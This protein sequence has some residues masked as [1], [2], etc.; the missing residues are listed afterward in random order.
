MSDK[1]K[2]THRGF[3][4]IEFEDRNKNKY[5]LQKSSVATEDCIWLGVD[6]PEL[7][8]RLHLSREDV[9]KLLPFLQKFVESG[10]LT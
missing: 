10:E 9:K 2:T 5:S 4:Y 6:V 8:T 7:G 1:I 3:S